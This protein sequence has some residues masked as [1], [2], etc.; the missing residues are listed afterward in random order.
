MTQA[1]ARA[2]MKTHGWSYIEHTRHKSRIKYIY[3]QRR[4]GRKVADH[5]ICPLSK[6]DT[7]TEQ[8]LVAK[9]VPKSPSV[10]EENY[11]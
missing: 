6:L 2:I 8:E 1:E 5:Y 10:P 3:A 7:L 9:L 11:E 4:Q